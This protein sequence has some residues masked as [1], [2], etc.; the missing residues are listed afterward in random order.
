[1]G[2]LIVI[3]GCQ[4]NT[5]LITQ[6]LHSPVCATEGHDSLHRMTRKTLRKRHSTT[7]IKPSLIFIT[8]LFLVEILMFIVLNKKSIKTQLVK[9]HPML[10]GYFLTNNFFLTIN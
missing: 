6:T 4:N 3:S 2:G 8:M 1:M 10:V 7:T 5:G 9:A